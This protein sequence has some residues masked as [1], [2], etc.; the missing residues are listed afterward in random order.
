MIRIDLHSPEPAEALA[1]GSVGQGKGKS[2]R[3]LVFEHMVG[4]PRTSQRKVLRSG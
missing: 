1:R 2:M 4:T 3:R